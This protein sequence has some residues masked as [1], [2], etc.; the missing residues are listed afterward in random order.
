M[1]R[2]E[3]AAPFAERWACPKAGVRRISSSHMKFRSRSE[4]RQ[5]ATMTWLAR[6]LTPRRRSSGVLKDARPSARRATP[7]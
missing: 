7:A 6:P 4:P 2:R 1:Y 5:R 3:V